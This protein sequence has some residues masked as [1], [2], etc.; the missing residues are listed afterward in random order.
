MK[1]QIRF[2]V[3][4]TNSSMMHSLQI[5]SKEDYEYF[6]KYDEDDNWVWDRYA[7]IWRKK[8][9]CSEEDLE[10]CDNSY[11]DEEVDYEIKE[12]TTEHGDVVVAI[13]MAQEA[14]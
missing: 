7:E 5:M 3:F 4:E 8:S 11:F 6:L 9:E 2:N 1:K 10:E 13:S 14:Y 12:F